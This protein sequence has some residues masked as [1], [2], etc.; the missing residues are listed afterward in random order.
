MDRLTTTCT[1]EESE[2]EEEESLLL[3]WTWGEA[4]ALRSSG[5]S[6]LVS[7]DESES[8]DR[9]R[10]RIDP[11]FTAGV[12]RRDI[13]MLISG[14]TLFPSTGVLS[15]AISAG[16]AL[17][18]SLSVDLASFSLS[19]FSVG[20]DV[21]FATALGNFFSMDSF[22]FAARPNFNIL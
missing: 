5:D 21:S 8:C 22:A 16:D 2:D 3:R 13:N 15:T 6:A 18:T 12:T 4:K 1:S 20:V 9:D 10:L 17:F 11:P 14:D 7:V 19:V